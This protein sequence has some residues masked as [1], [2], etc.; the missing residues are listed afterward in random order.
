MDNEEVVNFVEC[1]RNKC[2]RVPAEEA[3][4]EI[5][6]KNTCIAQILAEEARIR[7]YSIVEE[8][9]V[10]IDDISCV[11]VEIKSIGNISRLYT[12]KIKIEQKKAVVPEREEFNEFRR[13][14]TLKEVS[15]RDPKR[16]TVVS[17][18]N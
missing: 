4:N 1:F 12:K 16:E 18:A 11:V 8:E 13:A 17:E 3:N 6:Y 5:S 15:I 7:W 2:P 9:D 14:P 10:I